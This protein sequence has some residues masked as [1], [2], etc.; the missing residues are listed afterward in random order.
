MSKL[1]RI[2]LVAASLAMLAAIFT[3][4]YFADAQR[5]EMNEVRDI[6][7][8]EL[9]DDIASELRPAG[10]WAKVALL[11]DGR[12]G[13]KLVESRL[14]KD[15]VSTG[16]VRVID[17]EFIHDIVPE[18]ST[19]VNAISARLP[20]DYTAVIRMPD[21]RQSSGELIMSGE[22]EV[23]SGGNTLGFAVSHE[24]ERS[25][26]D[27][28]YFLISLGKVN[29]ALR[30]ILLV[31]VLGCV[32]FVL[33]PWSVRMF[34]GAGEAKKMLV[35]AKHI[36]TGVLFALFYMAF[37]LSLLNVIAGVPVILLYSFYA[38]RYLLAVETSLAD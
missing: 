15:L 32:P 28:V 2:A 12:P 5:V 29:P 18:A 1:D 38:Y 36:L 14:S 3:T 22:V 31:I 24:V 30:L 26:F 35:L 25:I 9:S 34:R 7:L 4:I 27:P 21:F 8:R 20:I 17:H 11:H 37:E 6:L 33:S 16:F 10:E 19:E 13:S 23:T